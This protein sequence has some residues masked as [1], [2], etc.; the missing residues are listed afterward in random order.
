MVPEYGPKGSEV[1]TLS[2]DRV[3]KGHIS[4]AQIKGRNSGI[5]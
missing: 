2:F 5:M 1:R 3:Y 4:V